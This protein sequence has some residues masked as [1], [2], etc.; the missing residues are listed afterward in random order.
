MPRQRLPGTTTPIIDPAA[1][2]VA[3]CA[4]QAGQRLASEDQRQGT[5][6]NDGGTQ[7]V[8]RIGANRMESKGKRAGHATEMRRQPLLCG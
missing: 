7:P 4:L 5:G 2:A 3:G 6:R 8:R 1:L